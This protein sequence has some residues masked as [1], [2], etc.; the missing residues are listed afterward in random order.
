MKRRRF[1][2]LSAAA[3]ALP[4]VADAHSTSWQSQAL[5]GQLRVD[6]RGGEG[7][8]QR[9]LSAI[10]AIIAEVEAAASLF[11]PDSALVRLN[12]TG[13]LA[14]PPPVLQ[15]LLGLSDRLH[16]VTGGLFDPTVQPLWR[17]LAERASA[18]AIADAR[19]RIGWHNVARQDGVRLAMGQA[20]TFNGIAQG[21]AADRVAAVL[22]RAGYGPAL[23]DMGEFVALDGPFMLGIADPTHGMLGQRQLS[24]GALATSSPAAQWLPG[25]TH[26]LGP[27][28]QAPVWSTITVEADSAVLADGLS[29]AFCLMP[30]TMIRAACAN[31]P[32]VRRVTAVTFEGEFLTL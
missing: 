19:S 10:A 2:A 15:D 24:A 20:L 1:L 25:G 12:E 5:G 21:Y 6:L 14:D 9:I 3:L 23:I 11:R 30:A 32:E 28:D 7:M 29:T 13:G 8:N 16:A 26:I 27:L 18:Q 4:P 31:L 17:A 22:R